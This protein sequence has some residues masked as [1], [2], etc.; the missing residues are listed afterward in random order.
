MSD[1]SDD[2]DAFMDGVGLDV[3]PVDANDALMTRLTGGVHGTGYREIHNYR[4]WI[5]HEIFAYFDLIKN[6][7]ILH[8]VNFADK[9]TFKE[10]TRLDFIRARTKY[11]LRMKYLPY[12]N[13]G[14]EGLGK[15]DLDTV[16]DMILKHEDISPLLTASEEDLPKNH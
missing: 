9:E 12:F 16:C 13:T 4:Y 1:D 3:K 14:V 5:R 2:L 8:R 15:A 6:G 7:C 10:F 11:Y